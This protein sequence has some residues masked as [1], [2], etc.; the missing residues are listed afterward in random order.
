MRT[1]AIVKYSFFVLGLLMLAGAG[2]LYQSNVDFMQ[3]AVQ[4][5]GVVLALVPRRSSDSATTYALRVGFIAQSGETVTFTTR[6]SSSHPDHVEGDAVSVYHE[7]GNPQDARLP[8][9]D[10]WLGVTVLA[11]LGVAFAGIGGGVMAHGIIARRRQAELEVN[12]MPVVLPLSEVIVDESLTVNGRHPWRLLAQWHNPKDGKLYAYR[13][14]ALWFDP[15]QYISEG[16]EVT[17]LV[18]RKKPKRHH[19]DLSFLPEPA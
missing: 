10:M 15:R 11:I 4:A 1:I 2:A 9:S 6:S 14:A 18:D 8:G 3:R 19:M 17:V 13:S 12:G 5:E 16:Q 7:P